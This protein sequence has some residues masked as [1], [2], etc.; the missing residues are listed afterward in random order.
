MKRLTC[1]DC[2]TVG[3]N[4]YPV[5]RILPMNVPLCVKC[6]RTRE[7]RLIREW[8]EWFRKNDTI[9]RPPPRAA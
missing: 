6:F 4:A 7:K 1:T 2:H 3:T 9:L 8:D 5:R